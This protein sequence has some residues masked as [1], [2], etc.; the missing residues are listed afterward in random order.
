MARDQRGALRGETGKL[1]AAVRHWL[2]GGAPDETDTALNAFG[3]VREGAGEI[4]DAPFRVHATNWPALNIFCATWQQWRK[5][6]VNNNLVRDCMDWTQVEAALN[7]SGIK[8]AGWPLI[9]EGL[10]AAESEAL[11]FLQ[12]R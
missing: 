10:R 3:L 1:R 12:R 9:F 4:L 5:V 7:L 8:R 2:N 6:A 11:K